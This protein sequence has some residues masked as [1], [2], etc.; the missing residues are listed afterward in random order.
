MSKITNLKNSKYVHISFEIALL[1]KGI[2]GLLEIIG[3]LLLIYLTPNRMN[4]ITSY[5]T[6]HELSEDP[7]DFVANTLISI[8]NHFSINTQYFG[9]I[10]LLTHGF[11]KCII[12][13]L[14]WMRK[15]WAYPVSIIA[16]LLFILY[17]IYRYF[18]DPSLLLI[19]LTVFDFIMIGLTYIEYQRMKSRDIIE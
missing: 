1:F 6:Q 13:F 8:A 7:R 2:D 9:I 18:I 16:L 3:G 5:L 4:R 15:L 17:Q 12:I 14:L 11:I 10:Y 19:L